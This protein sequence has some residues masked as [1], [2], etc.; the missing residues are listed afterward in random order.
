MFSK[1]LLNFTWWVN[2][3]DAEGSNLFEGGFLGLDNI[4]PIDRSHVPEGFVLEQSDATAWMAFYCL[5]MLE[6]ARE[7]AQRIPALDDLVI[8][9]MEHFA[10][11][12][13]A[14][15]TKDLWDEQ[16]GFFYDM[17]R[18]PDGHH[19]PLRVRSMVGIMPLF[20][21]KII[22][23]DDLAGAQAMRK[24]FAAIARRRG[25]D[26]EDVRKA[27]ILVDIGG[28]RRMIVGVAARGRVRRILAHLFDEDSFLS[29]YGLRAVSRWHADHPFSVEM[30]GYTATI[31]YEPA[32]STTGMFGRQLELAGTAVDAAQLPG[33][34]DP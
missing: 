14:M 29:P 6:I 1:L 16:D 8:K 3:Q 27:G 5:N 17:L 34:A 20:A 15:H 11:I 26:E 30:P 9:F 28:K 31:D 23:E 33:T 18:G 7:L 25:I 2:R 13:N 19:V 22:G 21:T 12:S 24:G 32:E 10:L 4:G